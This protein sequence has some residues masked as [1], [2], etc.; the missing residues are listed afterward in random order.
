M[1]VGLECA[2]FAPDMGLDVRKWLEE[3]GFGQFAGLFESNQ[4]DGDALL[5]L[6]DEH[7]RELGIP[8]GQRVKLR[9]AIEGLSGRSAAGSSA[10]RRH[11]TVMFV[12]L[13]GSSALS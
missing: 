10:E 11:L 6:T 2:T 12:D 7:L 8:L 5:A 1:Q 3:G 13:V 4:V 9:A